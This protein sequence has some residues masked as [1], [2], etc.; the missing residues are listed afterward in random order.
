MIG[1]SA[2]D[3]KEKKTAK[4]TLAVES[5]HETEERSK[6]YKTKKTVSLKR[7]IK[8]SIKENCVTKKS[9]QEQYKRKLRH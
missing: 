4:E 2:K 1:S 5:N 3:I 7:V 6:R 8:S 9:D